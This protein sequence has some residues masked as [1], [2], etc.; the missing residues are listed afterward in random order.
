MPLNRSVPVYNG[1]EQLRF[2]SHWEKPYLEDIEKDSAVMMLLSIKRRA[3]PKVVQ[4]CEDLPCHLT[5]AVYLNIPAVP[6]PVIPSAA[7]NQEKTQE[8]LG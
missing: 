7:A 1:Q 8:L 3:L 5:T 2:G 4:N 6:S